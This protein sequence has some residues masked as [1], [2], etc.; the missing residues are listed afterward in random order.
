MTPTAVAPQRHEVTAEEKRLA[1]TAFKQALVALSAGRVDEARANVGFAL[2]TMDRKLPQDR[3]I[4]RIYAV[5]DHATTSADGRVLLVTDP[6]SLLAAEAESGKV[7][8]MVVHDVGSE[9]ERPRLSPKGGFVAAPAGDSIVLY[10]VRGL[11]ELTRVAARPAAPFAFLDEERLV[12]VRLGAK[13]LYRPLPTKESTRHI[14]RELVTPEGKAAAGTLVLPDAAEVEAPSEQSDDELVIIE[15]KTGKVLKT[16]K[17]TAQLESGPLRRVTSLPPSEACLR[18]QDC[19]RF[20]FNPTPIGRRVE[21]LKIDS[22]IVSAVWRGGSVSIHRLRDGKLMGSF[23]SRGER[24]KPGLVAVIADPPRAAVA[25]SLPEVGRGSEPAVSVTALVDLKAGRL[26]ELVDECRWAT[27]L[28]FSQDGR[29][30]MVGDLRKACLHDAKTGRHLVTTEEVRPSLGPA[31]EQEDVTVR[32]FGDDRWLLRT[33]DGSY[34]VFDAKSGK[35]QLRGRLEPRERLVAGASDTLYLTENSGNSATL[36]A[37][38]PTGI[39]RRILRPEELDGR[40]FPDE[41]KS[42]PEGQRAATVKAVL[43]QT[44]VVEGFRLPLALCGEPTG[45]QGTSPPQ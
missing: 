10:D 29:T 24:W 38:G 42:T 14:H 33:L 44:C 41:A 25:T 22:G 45:A 27:G 34:G 15:F 13:E 2:T 17:L 28:G 18:N 4:E 6:E 20:A 12:T 39:Q 8:G 30:L 11:T 40:T 37:L 32:S 36:V 5:V 21:S 43:L 31:D 9:A 1:G 26:I 3:T 7:L 19:E 23:R 16:L 35:A